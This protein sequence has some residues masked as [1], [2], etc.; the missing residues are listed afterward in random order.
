LCFG[1]ILSTSVSAASHKHDDR[2]TKAQAALTRATKAYS[3]GRFDEA[4][5]LYSEAYNLGPQPGLLFNIAQ[6]YRQVSDYETA[7]IYYRRYRNEARLSASD[8][9]V[10][11]NIVAEVEA[12]QA[13][14]VEQQRLNAARPR[15]NPLRTP[16]DSVVRPAVKVEEPQRSLLTQSLSAPPP[17]SNSIFK[18]WWF[19]AGVGS[20]AAGVVVYAALPPSSRNPTLGSVNAR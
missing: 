17:T 13:D 16:P 5:K 14:R 1:L 10:L 15:G 3:S 2:G 6:C 20:V 18:K 8:V 11:E 9:R 7:L 4:L 12:N 19:W